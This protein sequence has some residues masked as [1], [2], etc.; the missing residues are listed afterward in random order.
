MVDP[1]NTARVLIVGAGLAAQ[2]AA[3]KLAPRPVLVISPEPLGHGASSAWAQGGV[4]AAM[5]P[6]DTAEAHARDTLLAGAGTVDAAVAE[7]VTREARDHILDLTGL[8]TPFDR[9]QEGAYVLSR[10]AAH[11]FARVVRVR[12]DQAGAEIMRAL[13]AQLREAAHV[14]V[15][16]GVMATDLEV[17]GERV[18]GVAVARCHDG[19]Q[20]ESVVLRGPAVL[21]AGGGSGGLFA[22]TTNPPRIRGQVMGMAA[23]AGARIADAEFVQFHPTAIACGLDPA[24]LATEALRGE[25]AVLVNRLGARFMVDTHPDAELAPRDIVARAVYAQTQAGLAPALDTRQA[26]GAA[27]LTDFPA[28]AAACLQAGLDPVAQPIPVAAAAHY[29]MGGVATDVS[30]RSSLPGL[31][32][33]GEVASTGLHGANR[34]ASN[35]LLEALVYGRRCALS[36]DAALPAPGVAQDV[37]LPDLAPAEPPDT[38]LVA[39]LRQAMTEGAGVI[40]NTEGLTRTLAE[41]ARIEAAQPACTPLL[42]M[43]A[44]ATLIAAAALARR[45]SRGAHFRSDH[46]ETSETGQ[47]SFLTLAEALA[48]RAAAVAQ[49]EP[50]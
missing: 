44:T 29:H 25:G 4:A 22:L 36:I 19:G 5:D 8:G 50:A 15:L 1:I 26:L 34:L 11:S 17:S 30:G 12:G 3:L 7:A 16:E 45:E 37:Q 49:K 24:P 47:R 21:L 23:R 35:G 18:T 28:V 13:T 38:A 43:T 48:I 14:Q 33:C 41:I 6:A 9:T 31:W 46:P 10:E 2:Y 39:A 20:S 32:A 40:R 42:N 27:I